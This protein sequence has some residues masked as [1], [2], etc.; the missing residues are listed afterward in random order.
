MVMNYKVEFEKVGIRLTLHNTIIY[1]AYIITE[2]IPYSPYIGGSPGYSK[3]HTMSNVNRP[4]QPLPDH[5]AIMRYPRTMEGE[6]HSIFFL[7]FVCIY[8]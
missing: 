3:F 5:A 4:Q 1:N 8:S 2:S 6:A 7:F